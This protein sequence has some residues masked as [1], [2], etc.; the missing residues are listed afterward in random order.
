M[1]RAREASL[2]SKGKTYLLDLTIRLI[3]RLSETEEHLQLWKLVISAG[4]TLIWKLEWVS[5]S[6]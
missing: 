2:R 1:P 4:N 6:L 3:F 5:Y